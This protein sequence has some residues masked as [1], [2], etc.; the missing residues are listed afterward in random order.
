MSDKKNKKMSQQQDAEWYERK[1]TF[2]TN[3]KSPDR[4]LGLFLS[5]S[6]RHTYFAFC[7]DS[8]FMLYPFS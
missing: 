5:S 7:P 3:Q 1:H 2:A 6:S 4:M 8:N